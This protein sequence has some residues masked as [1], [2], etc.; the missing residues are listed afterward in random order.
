MGSAMA[1]PRLP[2]THIRADGDADA[3]PESARL[4]LIWG[5]DFVAGGAV[6]LDAHRLA[7][8]GDPAGFRWL[9]LNLADQ[10]TRRWIA[11]A[12]TLAPEVR[13]LLLSP[14]KHQR[15]LIVGD[16]VACAIHDFERDFD[17]S[18]TLQT[19]VF[20]FAL[21]P[22]LMLSTR[23]HPLRAA[24]IMYRRISHGTT[25]RD[26]A[27]ALDMLLDSVTE[28][29]AKVAAELTLIVQGAE[30][31][32]L[33]F[34]RAPDARALVDVRR[35][36]VQLQ[37]QLGGLRAVLHRLEHDVD[38]PDALLATVEKL[39]QRVLALD[40]DVIA[41]QGS[42]RQLR[43]EVDMA[44]TNRTNQNLYIL[45]L[46]TALLLPP[47]LVTGFFGMNTGG[48]PFEGEHHGT[49]MA[50]ALMLGAAIA[51]FVWLNASGFFKR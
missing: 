20:M 43:E 51:V 47:T 23:H 31:T 18:S 9:H 41:I 33:D 38:L 28:V 16:T 42:L 44:T 8:R 34:G 4:G 10:R 14:E 29:A 19:G 49:I 45:S 32:L 35:S 17:E 27:A 5:Y 2:L 7:P 25:P 39:L 36:A 26:A 21:T 15:A 37:R 46:L 50:I 1:T 22:Q 11:D 6:P 3:P 13:E 24:D 40:A 48:M 30:D 12:A